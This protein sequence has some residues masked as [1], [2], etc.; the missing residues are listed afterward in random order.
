MKAIHGG[1]AENDKIDSHQIA[2]LLRGGLLR[3]AYVYPAGMRSTRDLLRR[4]LHLVRKRG[5]LLAHSQNTRAQYNLP[6][7]SASPIPPTARASAR[8]SPIRVSGRAWTW[9]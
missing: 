4:R 9:T 7:S 6:S 8:I 1:K 3:Q 2:S 5:Q